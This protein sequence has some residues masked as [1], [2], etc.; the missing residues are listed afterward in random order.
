MSKNLSINRLKVGVVS[1]VTKDSDSLLGLP[2]R[3]RTWGVDSTSL[4]FPVFSLTSV[5]DPSFKFKFMGLFLTLLT[6]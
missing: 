6:I 1:L 5:L 2:F 4:Y 3:T